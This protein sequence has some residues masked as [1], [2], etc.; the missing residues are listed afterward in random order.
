MKSAV[1]ERDRRKWQE[2]MGNKSTLE[3]YGSKDEK[4]FEEWLDREEGRTVFNFRAGSLGLRN[5]TGRTVKDKTCQK[6]IE[7]EIQNEQHVV[8]KCQAY[9]IERNI[10]L[11][12]GRRIWG[13][14][15]GGG[16]GGGK[17]DGEFGWAKRRGSN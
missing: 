16:G 15:G 12:K 4:K 2:G 13:G 5:R 6:Y 9:R 14:G 3:K 17:R 7:G 1:T 10:M 8:L 11:G